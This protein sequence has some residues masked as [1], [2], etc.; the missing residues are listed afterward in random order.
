MNLIPNIKFLG[1]KE[2]VSPFLTENDI[3]ILT[4]HYE[5]L[6]ISIIEAMSYGLPIIAS[7]VGGNDEMIKNGENGYLVDNVNDLTEAILKF[8]NDPNKVKFMGEKSKEKF[9]DEYIL[10]TDMN[11]I[12][13]EYQKLLMSAK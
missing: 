2:N 12:N 6:P 8:I 11:N 13:K 9:Y 1:F 5:G 4:S 7:D 10:E 3:Y